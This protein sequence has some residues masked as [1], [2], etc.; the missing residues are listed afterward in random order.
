[1][2]NSDAAA[3]KAMMMGHKGPAGGVYF[4]TY[5]GAAVHFVDNAHGFWGVIGALL[6]AI[7]WPAFLVHRVFDVL[8]I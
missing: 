4:L 3:K 5:I 7:V 8:H 1:M 2:K 6:K